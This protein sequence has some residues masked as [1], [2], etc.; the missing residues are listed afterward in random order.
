MENFP[1]HI[2]NENDLNAYAEYIKC[3]NTEESIV[4]HRESNMSYIPIE[5]KTVP[6]QLKNTAFM[7]AF[8]SKH[9]GKL[10]K[11]ETLIGNRLE[12]KIGIL[13]TVG[14]GFLVLRQYRS[15]NTMLCDI[16]GIKYITIIHDN[17]PQKLIP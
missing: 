8:L 16:Y 14:A 13:M 17:D 9:I 12:T 1:S 2:K 3:E 5:N 15:N 7:P 11:V 4:S 10:I 6:Q